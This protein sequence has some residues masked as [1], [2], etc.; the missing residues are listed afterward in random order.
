MEIPPF[1]LD[2]WMHE[3]ATRNVPYD[4]SGSTGPVWH[5]RDVLELAALGPEALSDVSQT[6]SSADGSV[7]LREAVA[8]VH[9]AS[10]DDVQITTGASEALAILTAAHGRP[11]GNVVVPDPGYPPFGALADIFGMEARRYPLSRERHYE[12]DVEAVQRLIDERTTMVIVNSPHNPTGACVGGDELSALHEAARRVGA[13]LVLD[14]VF[15]PVYHHVAPPP[16]LPGESTVVV[17]DTAKAL[18]LAGLRIGWIVDREPR[19]RRTYFDLRA[20]FT[21]SSTPLAERLATVAVTRRERVLERTRSVAARNLRTLTGLMAR[22]DRLRWVPPAGG[23]TAFPWLVG[24]EDARPFCRRAAE[25]GVLLAPGDCFG[26]PAHFRIG[27]GSNEPDVF[28]AGIE[29]LE[30]TAES[31]LGPPSAS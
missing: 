25:R 27:F 11:S 17:G 23:L 15:H 3:H 16:D 12:L 1:E 8:A 24:L 21:L 9:G 19:R 30:R 31:E 29:V 2:H 18:A 13:V 4:L 20:Y 10:A 7:E 22:S 26:H 28:A 6:Y 5:T 14:R